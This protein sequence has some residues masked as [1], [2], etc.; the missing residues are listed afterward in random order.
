M[1]KVKLIKRTKHNLPLLKRELLGFTGH[2]LIVLNKL[3]DTLEKLVDVY[4]KKTSFA[5]LLESILLPVEIQKQRMVQAMCGIRLRMIK[6]AT[7]EVDEK[8][9]KAMEQQYFLVKILCGLHD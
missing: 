4:K 9:L 3:N 2:D 5:H 8:E 1:K 7:M 6:I